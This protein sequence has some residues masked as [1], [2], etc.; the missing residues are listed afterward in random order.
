MNWPGGLDA[1]HPAMASA[2]AAVGIAAA[3]WQRGRDGRALPATA[4]AVAAV[5]AAVAVASMHPLDAG[6][7]VAVIVAVR[8]VAARPDDPDLGFL[9]AVSTVGVWLAVAD[10]E[11][12]VTIAATSVG[13]AIVGGRRFSTTG[14]RVAAVLLVVVAAA[15]GS[16]GRAEIVGGLGCVGLLLDRPRPTPGPTAVRW[17]TLGAH[18]AVVAFASRWARGWDPVVAVPAV[19]ASLA[20]AHMVVW[21]ARRARPET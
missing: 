17:T 19:V 2:G 3:L 20:V 1:Y 10:T 8:A 9:L 4:T 18:V 6:A 12:A 7:F 16:G 5:V 21:S 13:A 15:G 11:V 14:D